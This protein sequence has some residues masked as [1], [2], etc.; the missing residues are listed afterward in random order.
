SYYR[1]IRPILVQNCQGCHQPAKASGGLIMISHAA[2][3]KSGDSDL[4]G[5]VP[6]KPDES[7]ILTQITSQD[8]KPPVM[9]RGKDPLPQHQVEL[10]KKWIEQGAKD[11]TPPSARLAVV[12]ADHPPTYTLPPVITS[13]DYSPD[14]NLLAVA[15]YHEVLLHKADGSTLVAR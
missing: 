11:D 7:E 9:P 4:P 14:G 13:L 2:L 15:G 5:I 10:I 6:G 12:D 1:E 3:L 8:G